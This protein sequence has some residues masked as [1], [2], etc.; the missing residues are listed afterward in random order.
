MKLITIREQLDKLELKEPITHYI[1]GDDSF[2]DF[3]EFH[4]DENIGVLLEFTGNEKWL[5]VKFSDGFG[6]EGQPPMILWT[7]NYTI[8]VACYDGATWLEKLPSRPMGDIELDY[9]GGG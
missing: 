2:R 6:G 9:V 7:E 4:G 3:K 1:M 8:F 5:D